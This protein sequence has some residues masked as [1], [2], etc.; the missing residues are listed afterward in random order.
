M[1]QNSESGQLTRKY[2]QPSC[3]G[4]GTVTIQDKLAELRARTDQQLMLVIRQELDRALPMAKAAVSKASPLYVRA[5]KA[6]MKVRPLVSK[7]EAVSDDDIAKLQA[8]LKEVEAALER[9]AS[10][11]I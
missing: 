2:Y 4:E 3:F 5:E 10:K 8:K 7:V 9:A 1:P 11:G 6:Y